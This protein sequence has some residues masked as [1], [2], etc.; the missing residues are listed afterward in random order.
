MTGFARPTELY[1]PPGIAPAG[2]RVYRGAVIGLGGI[3][4]QA[5]LPGF[6]DDPAV[7]ARLKIVASVDAGTSVVP[8]DGV[9]HFARREQLIE[10]GPIDFVDICTPTASHLDLTLWA[11]EQGYHVLCE[12][13]VAT[14]R[15][16]ARRIADA[17]RSAGRVVMPC[18]Q[19]RYNPVWLRVREWLDGGA[20]G[21]W[22]LAEFH[23]YRMMADRGTSTDAT[24]WRGLAAHSRGGVLLDHGTHLIYQ[25]LDA[26][27][28]VPESVRAWTGQLR[29]A[30][31]DVEDSAHLLLQFGDRLGVMFLTWAARHRENRVR[32]IGEHGMVEWIGGELRLDRGGEVQSFDY[33][34][35]LQKASYPRWFSGLFQAFA[36]A[37]DVGAIEPHL[38][39]L[40]D[41]AAVLEG[42]YRSAETGC[43]E[44]V[45]NR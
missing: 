13:P 39:D 22:H 40:A 18:H 41:V 43:A 45:R 3:A 12:K 16:E 33:S 17:A 24:P 4:R 30:D 15:A 25:L 5:H 19:Y 20:I 7:S 42:A 9:Q 28:G 31:Y 10:A 36:H 11:L 14:T 37:M 35:Q 21:R 44:E 2:T 26:A 29:H 1:A 38:Q 27:A 8:L 23:V 6:L 32:F 34:A